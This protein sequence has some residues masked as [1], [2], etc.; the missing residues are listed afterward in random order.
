MVALGPSQPSLLRMEWTKFDHKPKVPW[1]DRSRIHQ[2]LAIPS[3]TATP[4][5]IASTSATPS[6]YYPI[7]QSYH[8]TI[9]LSHYHTIIPISHHTVTPSHTVCLTPC[10]TGELSQKASPS[11]SLPLSRVH[12]LLPA[13]TLPLHGHA[14]PGHRNNTSRCPAGTSSRAEG[15]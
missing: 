5:Q 7:I 8:H 13:I 4:S 2:E 12:P 11:A 1:Y 14:D 10:M 6:R 9:V 15:G 3:T